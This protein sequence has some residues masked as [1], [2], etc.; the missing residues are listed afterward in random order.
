MTDNFEKY[1]DVLKEELNNWLVAAIEGLPDAAVALLVV[2]IFFFI[3]RALSNVVHRL[4]THYGTSAALASIGKTIVRFLVFSIGLIIALGL[5]GLQKAVFSLLAGAGI[6]G[7]ALGFAFQDLASNFIA[8]LFM[9]FRKPFNIGDVISTNDQ[10]GTVK[11]INMRNTVIETFEGQLVVM[12]NKMVFENPL[13]NYSSTGYRRVSLE[14]GVG[15]ETDLKKA[16]EILTQT[17]ESFDFTF[18]DKGFNIYSHTFADSSINF[19]I[20]YWIKYPSDVSYLDAINDG[21]TAIHAA[22]EQHDINIPFPIRT[23]DLSAS[24]EALEKI[25]GKSE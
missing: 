20:F 19:S 2:F 23:V 8:G 10:M 25:G 11:H 7:L 1:Y 5:L 24:T 15:Y 14:V 22:F 3:S 9:A 4:L 13:S 21:I 18:K 17:V 12:P 16:K 6:I